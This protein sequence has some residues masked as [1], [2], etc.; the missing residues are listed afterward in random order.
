MNQ[1]ANRRGT[2]REQLKGEAFQEALAE[3][4]PTHCTPERMARVAIAAVNRTPKLADCSRESFFGAMLT[5]SQ[6]GLEPDGRLAHLIPYGRECQL[7]IDYKGLVELAYRSGYVRNI[8]ADVVREGDLFEY[9]MGRV[10][11]HVPHFLRRD[12]EKPSEPGDIYAV[13]AMVELKDGPVKTE[14]LSRSQVEDVRK[15]SSAGRSGPWVTDWEEMAKKTAFR[16]CS[17][18]VPLSAEIRGAFVADDDTRPPLRKVR[19]TDFVLDTAPVAPAAAEPEPEPETPGDINY[20]AEIG[21]AQNPAD[22]DRVRRYLAADSR[23]G[24][25]ERYVLLEQLEERLAILEEAA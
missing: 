16:R 8:H 22:L 4:L 1:I 17:K 5:C 19:K 13:Y 21:T 25:E 7:V 2:L 15:R 24:D 3:I 9:S 23:V 11:E 14:V 18:W 20:A 6:Y 10:I 12:D